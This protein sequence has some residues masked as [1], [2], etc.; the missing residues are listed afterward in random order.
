MFL[1]H[2]GFGVI[3]SIIC[4]IGAAVYGFVTGDVATAAQFAFIAI[5]LG[6][7]EVSL[8]FDNAVV[9]AKVLTTMDRV[10]RRRFLTWGIA[11]A[12]V[13]MRFVFPILI[14]MVTASLGFGQVVSLA[15]NNPTEY[16][17]HL[18]DAHVMISAFGGTFLFLVFLHYFLDKTKDVHWIGPIERRLARAGHL[19]KVEV[20]ITLGALVALVSLFVQPVE[21]YEALISGSLGILTYLV[22]KSLAGFFEPADDDDSEQAEA[23]R[24]QSRVISQTATRAGAM[25]FLYL[26]VL[27][28]SFSLDGVIGAF[29]I[30]KEIVII[31]AGL[32]IGAVFVR[33]MTIWLV[34]A[35][36]LTEYRFLEHGAHYGIGALAVI[37][38]LS[39]NRNVHIPELFTGLIGL[40][41]ILLSVWSSIRATRGENAAA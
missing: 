15:F 40:S 25:S 37:M 32:A 34:D 17:E 33:S 30:S 22:V 3:F 31:A 39:M 8:S 9:N 26:E 2:F 5:V 29:A 1:K 4:V 12:V 35:G 14:V 28:A 24:N 10:W 20:S 23:Q 18:H 19:D 27:D 13:G 38:L 7:M 6:V 41:F 16:S 36:T 21:K 11:I